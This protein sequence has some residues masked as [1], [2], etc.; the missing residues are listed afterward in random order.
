[1]S[2][3]TMSTNVVSNSCTASATLFAP[4][5]SNPLASSNFILDSSDDGLSSMTNATT[6]VD[7]LCLRRMGMPSQDNANQARALAN[8][9]Y[10]TSVWMCARFYSFVAVLTKC[11]TTR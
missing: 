1:M 5:T 7:V 10:N 11:R 2:V 6:S 4:T 8:E 3:T 9:T